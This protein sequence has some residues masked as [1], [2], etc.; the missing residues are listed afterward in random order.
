MT[1]TMQME[2][3]RQHAAHNPLR[4]PGEQR[5]DVGILDVLGDVACSLKMGGGRG[6]GGEVVVVVTS[7]HHPNGQESRLPR[8]SGQTKE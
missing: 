6:E 4:L 2:G 3:G 8:K 7:T 5:L 1:H